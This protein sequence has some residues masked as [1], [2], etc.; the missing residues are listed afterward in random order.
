MSVWDYV[1]CYL[2]IPPEKDGDY[3]T[4]VNNNSVGSDYADDDYIELT[5]ADGEVV[6]F[7][8]IAGIKLKS[9]YY[10]ILQPEELLDGMAEDEAL[11]FKVTDK[12]NGDNSYEIE[13]DDDIIDAVFDEYNRLLDEQ[14]A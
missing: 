9:G 7:T 5:T 14:E 12:G 11:V 8:E 4:S 13:L 2:G 10:A 3:D 1:K 6:R